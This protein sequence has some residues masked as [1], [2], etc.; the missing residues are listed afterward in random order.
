MKRSIGMLLLSVWLIFTGLAYL[1]HLS[2][3]GMSTLMAITATA[4]G[5]LILMGL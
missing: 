1:L 2:F 3:S 4:A 5:I